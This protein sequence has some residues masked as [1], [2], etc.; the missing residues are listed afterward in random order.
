MIS[1]Q[2]PEFHGKVEFILLS[3]PF[4]CFCLLNIKCAK[5]SSISNDLLRRTRLKGG[6]SP[7][8]TLYASVNKWNISPD[9]PESGN[10]CLPSRFMRIENSFNRCVSGYPKSMLQFS[11]WF[12]Y[13]T[14][15]ITTLDWV[16]LII[17]F[18]LKVNKTLMTYEIC[19]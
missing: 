3:T 4:N 16:N 13:S 17:K 5:H 12:R 11:F 15:K 9:K 18:I 1:K 6:S 7:W 8:K 10:L 2:I 19:Y 14:N